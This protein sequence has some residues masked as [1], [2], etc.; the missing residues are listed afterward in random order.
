MRSYRERESALT[1]SPKAL[2][3]RAQKRSYRERESALTESP[4][5][6]LPKAFAPSQ[7]V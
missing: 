2:L 4:K 1:E 7:D 6:L 3:P 5:T